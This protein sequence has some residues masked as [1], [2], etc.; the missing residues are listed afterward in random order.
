MADNYILK[1]KHKNTDANEEVS[2]GGRIMSH[3]VVLVP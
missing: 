2:K 3:G 1:I